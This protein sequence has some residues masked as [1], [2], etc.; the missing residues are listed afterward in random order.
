[1]Q[2]YQVMVGLM[3]GVIVILF[4]MVLFARS[5]SDT[6]ELKTIRV[7]VDENRRGRI[8]PAQ[9]EDSALGPDLVEMTAGLLF[10]I[11][12]AILLIYNL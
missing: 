6:R 12:I 9:E 4:F 1:M 8:P 3:M 2:A 10:V 5:K 11:M 7:R